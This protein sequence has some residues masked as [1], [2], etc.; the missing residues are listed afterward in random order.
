MTTTTRSPVT[1]EYAISRLVADLREFAALADA[2]A[3]VGHHS[4]RTRAKFART[5]QAS[6]ARLADILSGTTDA[7]VWMTTLAAWDNLVANMAPAL[8]L[9]RW[10][11]VAEMILL[12][13]SY[14]LSDGVLCRTAD[15][16]R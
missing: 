8:G 3:F 10:L 6:A 12:G 15:A 11:H 16:T 2:S 14:V 4:P 5:Q 7:G 9:K 1:V 13:A